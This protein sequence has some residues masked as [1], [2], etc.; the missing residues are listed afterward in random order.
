MT[1]GSVLLTQYQRVTDG[2]TDGRTDGQLINA[3]AVLFKAV[4]VRLILG[5]SRQ[6]RITPA[7]QQLRWLSIKFLMTF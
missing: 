3:T 4:S 5:L 7:L 6:S 1:I 2:R